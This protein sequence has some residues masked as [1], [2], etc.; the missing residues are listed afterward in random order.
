MTDSLQSITAEKK[1]LRAEVRK[2]RSALSADERQA[3]GDAI[4]AQLIKLVTEQ[5]ANSVSCYLALPSEPDTSG[6]LAWAA[7]NDIDA[8]LPSSLEGHRLGWIRP[9]GTGTTPGAHG[10]SE[11][12]GELLPGTAVGDVDLMLIPASAVD[13][14]G[15]RM[16]WGLGYYDRCLATL[17]RKPPIYAIVYDT[18]VLARVPAE[19]HDSPIDGAVTPSRTYHFASRSEGKI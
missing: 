18:D 16:G 11:P 2:R 12:N 14:N 8:L 15:M 19:P 13:L 4:T 5:N 7:E 17:E 3:A 9:D 1:R 10:I 6:F